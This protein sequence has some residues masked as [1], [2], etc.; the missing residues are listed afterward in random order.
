MTT[1]L[2]IIPRI[3]FTIIEPL[4]LVAGAVQPFT[5]LKFFVNS[6]IPTTPAI[7]PV[8]S[9]N[10]ILALQLCN[11]YALVGMI[12]VGLLYATREAHVVRNYL[13]ACAIGD[14]GHIWACYTAMG[15]RDFFDVQG[16]NATA[17]GNIGI[18]AF[19]LVSR[20]LY[21]LG[22]LGEDKSS[23]SQGQRS[24]KKA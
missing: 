7:A 23:R 19:Y 12:G 24:K 1:I 9:T 8:S 4:S 22:A 2:P 5:G 15:G 14:V 13:I 18:T 16:W 11:C 21:L 3:I 6:Q 20:I 17:W 10:Q